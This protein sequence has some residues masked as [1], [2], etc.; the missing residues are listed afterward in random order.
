MPRRR[1]SSRS[2]TTR[3]HLHEDDPVVPVHCAFS[4]TL[5][6]RDSI[7]PDRVVLRLMSSLVPSSRYIDRSIREMNESNTYL[8]AIISHVDFF[9]R[10]YNLLP[11]RTITVERTESTREM[12][13]GAT[14][15]RETSVRRTFFGKIPLFHGNVDSMSRKVSLN[16]FGQRRSQR[17]LI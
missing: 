6:R 9:A 3:R 16:E 11:E 2:T 12:S 7:E 15:I 14:S 5:F 17:R 4:H 10:I 1:R 13:T 8:I